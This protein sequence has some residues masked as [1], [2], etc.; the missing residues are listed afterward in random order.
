[1]EELKIKNKDIKKEF[2]LKNWLEE[3]YYKSFLYLPIYSK[4]PDKLQGRAAI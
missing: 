4:L 2:G 3:Q 1:M